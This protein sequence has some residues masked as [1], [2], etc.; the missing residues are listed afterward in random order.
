M[1]GRLR[2]FRRAKHSQSGV[3]SF[4]HV[5]LYSKGRFFSRGKSHVKRTVPNSSLNIK[6]KPE[7]CQVKDLTH[8]LTH[9]DQ[10]HA[11]A[12]RLHLLQRRDQDPEA[13]R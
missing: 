8:T 5:L 10:S 2:L 9:I 7:T 4:F 12:L 11:A 6:Y 3:K 13:G 1:P